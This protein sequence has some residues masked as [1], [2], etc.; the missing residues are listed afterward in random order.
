MKISHRISRLEKIN[1]LDCDVF[2][3]CSPGHI[4]V[5]F[6]FLKNDFLKVTGIRHSEKFMKCLRIA[7]GNM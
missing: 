3:N 2:W 7:T 5:M 4:D 1:R 6:R